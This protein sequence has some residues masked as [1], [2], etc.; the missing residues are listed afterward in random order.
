MP[1]VINKLGAHRNVEAVTALTNYMTKSDFF[2]GYNSRGVIGNTAESIIEG[3]EFTKRMYEKEDRKQ[4]CHM[5]IGTKREGIC[6]GEMWEIAETAVDYFY[7]MGFQCFY[8]IHKGSSSDPDYLHVHLAVNTVNFVSG[9]R[10]YENYGC[11]SAVR[12]VLQQQFN[13]YNWR[14]INDSGTYWEE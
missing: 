1:L 11:V 4:I 12:N 2:G 14:S 7:R 9:N 13:K 3:F 6:L 5:I 10:L 8:A